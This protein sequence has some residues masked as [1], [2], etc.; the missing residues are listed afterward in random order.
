MLLKTKTEELKVPTGLWSSPIYELTSA[1]GEKINI[2]VT[3]SSPS[4]GLPP[5][6]VIINEFIPF[7]KS[8]KLESVL[9]LGA[10]V[11]RHTIPF[12]KAGFQVYAVEFKELFNSPASMRMLKQAMGHKNFSPLM[13]PSDFLLDTRKFDAALLCNVL[14]I[15][16]VEK[17]RR[18]LLKYVAEKLHNQAYLLY[19]GSRT[20][21]YMRNR[22]KELHRVNDGHFVGAKHKY[23]TFYRDFTDRETHA[24]MAEFGFQRVRNLKNLLYLSGPFYKI[25][26]YKKQEEIAEFNYVKRV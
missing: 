4:I 2:D 14:Q 1:H 20:S 18:I 13:T 11:L 16:P 10:G 9:D 17:E 25:F 19:I 15:M 22:L 24:L 6:K 21:S 3:K 12:L 23:K 26:L 5:N 7:F 8:G